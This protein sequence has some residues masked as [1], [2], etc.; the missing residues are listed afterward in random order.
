MPGLFMLSI[1]VKSD[2]CPT[3]ITPG[4]RSSGAATVTDTGVVKRVGH[5]LQRSQFLIPQTMSKKNPA[6]KPQ[7]KFM[8]QKKHC[9]F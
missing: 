9:Y 3:Q 6:V 8:L 2:S 4:P 1:Q 5:H 7:N